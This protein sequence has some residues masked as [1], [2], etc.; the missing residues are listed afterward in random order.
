MNF[1]L[2]FVFGL[3][4][5][6]DL[7]AYSTGLNRTYFAP[8]WRWWLKLIPLSGFYLY[9]ASKKNRSAKP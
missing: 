8:P 9:F 6:L 2:G 5:G 4:L 7:W 1:Y 3:L